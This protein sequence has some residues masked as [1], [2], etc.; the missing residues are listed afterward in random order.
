MVSNA[1]FSGL[2]RG[3]VSVGRSGSADGLVSDGQVSDDQGMLYYYI[4]VADMFLNSNFIKN[5]LE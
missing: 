3:F 2:K 5:V 1:F 4:G